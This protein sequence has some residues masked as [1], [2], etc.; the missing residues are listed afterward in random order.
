MLIKLS[1]ER[2]NGSNAEID[3]INYH[4]CA[5]EHGDHVCEVDNK[6]HVKRFLSIQGYEMYGVGQDLQE[7]AES[8]DDEMSEQ[9]MIEF[10]IEEL[11]I[12]DPSDKDELAEYA[13]EMCDG[14][15][16]NKSKKAINMLKEIIDNQAE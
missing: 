4:F 9:E 7:D 12:S 15:K 1:I 11:G 13:L 14:L 5:N 3:G 6:A 10:A 16:L 2:K 8:K